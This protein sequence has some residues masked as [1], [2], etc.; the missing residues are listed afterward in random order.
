M[1]LSA[2]TSRKSVANRIFPGI[3]SAGSDDAK[4]HTYLL[5]AIKEAIEQAQRTRGD[6]MKSFVRLDELVTLGLAD[7]QGNLIPPDFSGG[8]DG[9]DGTGTPA[10]DHGALAGLGDDDHPQ[11]LTAGRGDSRYAK[12]VDLNLGGL[13]DVTLTSPAADDVLAYNGAS[14]INRPQVYITD[15][16]NF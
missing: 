1:A 9:D 3:R 14:W 12:L 8:G 7:E 16:G 13:T 15:G 4:S 2:L 6:K 5:R 10:T 11:Y